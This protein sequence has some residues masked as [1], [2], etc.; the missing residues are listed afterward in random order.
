[1]EAAPLI[2]ALHES[3]RLLTAVVQNEEVLADW[4]RDR[5]QMR[6]RDVQR[7]VAEWEE[8]RREQLARDG[9]VPPGPT[10]LNADRTYA[11]LSDYVHARRRRSSI[12]YRHQHARC[13]LALIPTFGSGRRSSPTSAR[14]LSTSSLS[15][16]KR[17]LD[18]S[19]ENGASATNARLRAWSSS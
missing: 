6:F 7:A 3:N 14:S 19:G 15:G 17:S 4:L 11:L 1:M 10:K 8:Q 5:G 9:V 16:A 2:R 18:S 13:R 12:A